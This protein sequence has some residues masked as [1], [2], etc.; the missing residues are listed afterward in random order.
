[1]R[2]DVSAVLS[3]GC[4]KAYI[5][6]C[7][8]TRHGRGMTLPISSLGIPSSVGSDFQKTCACGV[9]EKKVAVLTIFAN[10]SMLASCLSPGR[11]AE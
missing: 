7:F 11:N 5:S 1:M 6:P 3:Q 2:E 9:S 10:L 8:F 4:V